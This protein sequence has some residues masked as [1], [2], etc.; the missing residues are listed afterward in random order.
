[1]PSFS[2][3]DKKYLYY[4]RENFKPVL[5]F[6]FSARNQNLTGVATRAAWMADG[7][8]GEIGVP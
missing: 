7:K 3:L 6:H 8:G 5:D 4:V 2:A 1:M